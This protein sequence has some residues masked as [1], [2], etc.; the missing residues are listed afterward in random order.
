MEMMVHE[1]AIA[2]PVPIDELVTSRFPAPASG[3]DVE[4]VRTGARL[5]TSRG[6]SPALEGDER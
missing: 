2:Q 4:K 3:F 6:G 1:S 5:E